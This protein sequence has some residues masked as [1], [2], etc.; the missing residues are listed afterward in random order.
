MPR[1]NV[2]R[3]SAVGFAAAVSLAVGANAG[4]SSTSEPTPTPPEESSQNKVSVSPLSP[5]TCG[6]GEIPCDGLCVNPNSLEN[7]GTCDNHCAGNQICASVNEQ[8]QCTCPTATNG[9]SESFCD[10][11]DGCVDFQTNSKNCGGCGNVCPTGE[12]CVAGAC[13]CATA[14]YTYCPTELT[15]RNL[16]ISETNC[17]ACGFSCGINGIC[18]DGECGCTI[19]GHIFCGSSCTNPLTDTH[20]CGACGNA[21]VPFNTCVNGACTG[22]EQGV[23]ARV[24]RFA[25][26]D[27]GGFVGGGQCTDLVE[28]A[29]LKAKACRGAPGDYLWG[30][31]EAVGTINIG[32]II[33]M[34]NV[35]TRSKGY[36][37][38][39][40]NHSAIVTGKSGT[41]LTLVEQ[42]FPTGTD[43]VV[44]TFDT[45]TV[46]QG[47]YIFYAPVDC[48]GIQAPTTPI[49]GV[50]IAFA[51]ASLTFGRA[52]GN[53]ANINA[54]HFC[55]GNTLNN[56][57]VII[58]ETSGCVAR[59]VSANGHGATGAG[60]TLA[61]ANAAAQ[62]NC[63]LVGPDCG[64]Y[65]DYCADGTSSF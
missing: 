24:A 46:V 17:G 7:C 37:Y 57:S 11:G 29:M 62:K 58:A 4:C 19:A 41:V 2:V 56:C 55:M 8:L 49:N 16:Q 13:G 25:Q 28:D 61:A 20:N 14:G 23:G 12:A 47:I 31:R 35:V 21:C 60:T 26:E 50:A 63:A 44:G 43:T 15:C 45:S 53:S 38:S 42:N 59:W 52:F 30:T 6:I 5:D 9:D 64:Q 65:V 40:P 39:Y 54:F 18:T 34:E 3:I 22:P 10:P 51:S 1:S 32:D 48:S 33:Q 36:T 27:V